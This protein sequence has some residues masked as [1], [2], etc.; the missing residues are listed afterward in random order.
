ML[1][2]LSKLSSKLSAKYSKVSDNWLGKTNKF[3]KLINLWLKIDQTLHYSFCNI[4][5]I[6]LINLWL[7]IDRN[8]NS[9]VKC[10][11]MCLQQIMCPQTS[12][13][14]KSRTGIADGSSKHVQS[15]QQSHQNE[16]IDIF[17][18]PSSP[19]PNIS[20]TPL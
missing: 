5:F 12:K 15:K 3:I 13:C 17:V 16:V 2:I 7:K 20:R 6:K 9:Y 19:T 14:P 11:N 1:A 18:V 4:L 10:K 8:Q